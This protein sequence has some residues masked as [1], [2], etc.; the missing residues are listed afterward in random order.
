MRRATALRVGSSEPASDPG[1]RGSVR[2]A[3]LLRLAGK[4]ALPGHDGRRRR[5]VDS[6]RVLRIPAAQP[7]DQPGERRPL[8]ELHGVVVDA[9]LA[10]D[11]VHRHDVRVVELRGGLGLDAEPSDLA[12]VDR[13]GQRQDLQGD[14]AAQRA[15]DGLVHDPHAAAADLADDAE[16]AN[17]GGF[18]V[19]VGGRRLESRPA[20]ASVDDRG[21][22]PRRDVQGLGGGLDQVEAP[23]AGTE[24]PGD[25][26]VPADPVL[27]V[28][29]PTGLDLGEVG[30]QYR[31][32]LV[33]ALATAI[34]AGGPG[35][36]ERWPALR[37]HVG[38]S[39]RP[40]RRS[41]ARVQS[42]RTAPGDR[43]MR[44]ATSSK[45]S[46]SRFRRMITSR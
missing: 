11:R 18:R 35:A 27:G 34:D 33:L 38:S 23:Q 8:D 42:M 12:G 31:R 28:D 40:L 29:R 36:V 20:A 6:G 1:G 15:L 14:A 30:I 46:R 2:A 16:V 21:L 25:R 44:A 26:R 7:G 45:R 4:L 39:S 13:G 19:E 9:P 32:Q 10:A 41:S 43:P 22:G 24:P 37:D 17:P 3:L 5:R